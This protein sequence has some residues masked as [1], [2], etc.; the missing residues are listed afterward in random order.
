MYFLFK[1]V[2][3]FPLC[4]LQLIASWIAILLNSY[5]SSMKRVSSINLRLAYP[6]LNIEQ[7]QALL[8]ATLKSQCL[9]YIE[10]I[11]I[12]GMPQKYNVDLIKNIHGEQNLTEALANKKGVIV[13]IAHFGCWELLNAWLNL[14][15]APMIMYK[16]N[17]HKSVDRFML[18]ARQRLNATLVP[19]DEN[20]VRAIFKHL[21]QG[22]LTV[23]LPDHLPKASGGIYSEFFGQTT[24]STTLVSKLA[25]KTQCNVI[26]LSCIRDETSGF[27]VHCVRLSEDILSKD[28]QTSV[29][30]LNQNLESM[31]NV[32][33]DQYVW[34][35]K[36]FRKI[37]G[38]KNIYH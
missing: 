11:K 14:H 2:S 3:L 33:P 37:E 32:A 21:K 15:T 35:Y 6:E 5:N 23:I 31:I 24:L 27:D 16:P 13:V 25:S 28:L 9:T 7:H 38:Q 20:G 30:S 19:T 34:S 26:G 4:I 18:E 10:S 1:V 29:D 12:W 17:K 22:G 36:R 8:K